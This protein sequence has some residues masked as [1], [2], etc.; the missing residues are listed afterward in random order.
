MLCLNIKGKKAI[1]QTKLTYLCSNNK[2]TICKGITT[3]HT[4][5]VWPW[6]WRWRWRLGCCVRGHGCMGGV[7]VSSSTVQTL[8]DCA[9]F[10]YSR[11][12]SQTIPETPEGRL[13]IQMPKKF[14]VLSLWPYFPEWASTSSLPCLLLAHSLAVTWLQGYFPNEGK[15]RLVMGTVI[16]LE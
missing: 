9:V 7:P 13:A 2:Q 6:Q 15:T 4:P 14:T 1:P 8:L 12:H 10:I 3:V 16:I 5:R 11:L